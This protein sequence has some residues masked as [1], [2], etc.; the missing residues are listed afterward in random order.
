MSPSP[1]E[2]A[3]AK[4]RRILS[5]SLAPFLASQLQSDGIQDWSFKNEILTEDGSRIR[6]NT[7]KGQRFVFRAKFNTLD[8][9]EHSLILT[10]AHSQEWL[11]VVTIESSVGAA[12]PT[13]II[14]GDLDIAIDDLKQLISN[15]F[16]ASKKPH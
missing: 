10:I 6:E 11:P 15:I 1:E 7:I 9:V 2:I 5:D 3:F 12:V 4:K 16:L 14:T 8:E 13:T